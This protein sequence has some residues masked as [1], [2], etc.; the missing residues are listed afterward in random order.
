MLKAMQE[1][2]CASGAVAPSKKATKKRRVSSSVEKEAHREKRKKGASTSGAQLEET[3]KMGRAPTPPTPVSEEIPDL[4]LVIT[5]VKALSPEKRKGPERVPPLDYSKESLVES[6][7]GVVATR[8]WLGG[9]EVVKRLTRAHRNVKAT[10]KNFDEAMGQHVEVVARLEEL[11]V[12][13]AR[14]ERAAKAQ[15]EA[16]EAE[17]TAEKEVRAVEKEAL[18][19]ELDEIKAR[20]EQEAERLKSKA[21]EEFLKSP[22]FDALLAKK[23]W[24]NPSLQPN[25]IIQ[26]IT[27]QRNPSFSLVSGQKLLSVSIYEVIAKD[28]SRAGLLFA[29]FCLSQ[30]SYAKSASAELGLVA[31]GGVPPEEVPVRNWALV[32]SWSG[33]CACVEELREVGQCGTGLFGAQVGLPPGFCTQLGLSPEEF[34]S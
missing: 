3:P 18:G 15:R 13:R 29:T 7:T 19:A 28:E 21:K 26:L 4:P 31:S 33:L 12:L 17:L 20:A 9:G 8:Q 10:R 2:A 23:A 1:E 32:P 16:L 22:E 34:D 27:E 11:E 25:K 30:K 24:G 6:S 14:E 5:I